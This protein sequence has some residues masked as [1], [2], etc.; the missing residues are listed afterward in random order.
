[1]KIMIQRDSYGEVIDN[2]IASKTQNV[3]ITFRMSGPPLVL[4]DNV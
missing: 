4:S 1:M 2:L 3:N